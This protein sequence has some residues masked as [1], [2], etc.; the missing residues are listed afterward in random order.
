MIFLIYCLPE[1]SVILGYN[2]VS[3]D[4]LTHT[5]SYLRR[6][7]S[8]VKKPQKPQNLRI[9]FQP[10]S[11]QA[12]H[13]RAFLLLTSYHCWYSTRV[14]FQTSML[15][16]SDWLVQY[17]VEYG[18]S[19]MQVCEWVICGCKQKNFTIIKIFSQNPAGILLIL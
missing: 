4:N 8:S 13:S 10:V 9:T 16:V 2:A 11:C 17:I 3:I 18:M 15:V 5:A 1:D 19:C 6:K 14:L 12:Q 7:Q